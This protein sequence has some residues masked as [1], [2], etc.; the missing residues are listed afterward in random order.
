MGSAQA[1]QQ[2]AGATAES[3]TPMVRE[4]AADPGG[5]M[6]M[7]GGGPM[8]GDSRPGAGGNQGAQQG[9]AEALLL[10]Q[11]LKKDTLEAT[12]TRWVRTW[13]RTTS[14]RNRAGQIGA[15]IY[16]RRGVSDVRSEPRGRTAAR[17]RSAASTPA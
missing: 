13:R 3:A 5:K 1:E 15:R 10:A 14:R 17:A 6:M 11:A 16:A 9:A 2:K 12:P 7:G 4:A 8:G